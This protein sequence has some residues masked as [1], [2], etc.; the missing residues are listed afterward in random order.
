MGKVSP[1]RK[2]RLKARRETEAAAERVACAALKAAGKSCS[3][4]L[5][6]DRPFSIHPKACCQLDSDF[7]GYAI[8][9]PDSVCSRFKPNP[10]P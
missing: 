6:F 1:A 5:H 8:T 7:H 4:C 9:T 3:G 2:A 10:S